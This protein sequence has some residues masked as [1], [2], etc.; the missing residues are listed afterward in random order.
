MAILKGIERCEFISDILDNS[1]YL[2]WSK[3]MDGN[4]LF[5]NRRAFD[6]FKRVSTDDC[7]ECPLDIRSSDDNK[8]CSV[9]VKGE[10]LW[11]RY[12]STL[13]K[14]EGEDYI[15]VIARDIT[16]EK[17]KRIE[18]SEMLDEKISEWKREDREKTRKINETNREIFQILSLV[19]GEC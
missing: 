19:N 6:V 11:L 9:F 12:S 14:R 5:V 15:L 17:K 7:I 8:E 13:I 16:E 18:I 4:L 1:D 2:I 3:D 10:Q